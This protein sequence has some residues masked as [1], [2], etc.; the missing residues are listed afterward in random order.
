MV[1]SNFQHC[2][3]RSCVHERPQLILRLILPSGD[4]SIYGHGVIM[5]ESS[6]KC[7]RL[8][9]QARSSSLPLDIDY[10]S[11]LLVF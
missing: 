2:P 8:E 10:S 3:R 5:H 11:S 6:D 7:K 1:R 4:S 9:S